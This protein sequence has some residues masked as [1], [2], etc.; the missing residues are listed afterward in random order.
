MTR[1]QIGAGLAVG[2][3]ATGL[4]LAGHAASPVP[5]FA[6]VA[7]RMGVT[8]ALSTMVPNATSTDGPAIAPPRADHRLNAPPSVSTAQIDAILAGYGSPAAGQEAVL[9]ELGVQTGIDPAY[10]LAFWV[11]ES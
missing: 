7:S 5:R 8:V 1:A 4:R 3:L 2:L 10:A 11:V 6:L 9:Y